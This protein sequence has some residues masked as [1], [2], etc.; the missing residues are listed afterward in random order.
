MFT[1][2]IVIGTVPITY[3]RRTPKGTRSVFVPVGDTPSNERRLEIAHESTASKRVNSLAKV[4]QV[5]PHPVTNVL[6]EGSIQIK[7]V[8][9]AS[10]TEAQVQLLADHAAKF[11]VS[12]NVTK[13]FNQEQ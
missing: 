3:T 1:D 12:G 11:L 4:A 6:E 2:T 13:M 10:F 7:I 8:R 5:A 9:P